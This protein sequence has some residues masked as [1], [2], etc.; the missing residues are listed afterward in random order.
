MRTAATAADILVWDED[1]NDGASSTNVMESVLEEAERAWHVDVQQSRI[2]ERDSVGH[3]DEVIPEVLPCGRRRI[4]WR[5]LVHEGCEARS[6]QAFAARF[7]DLA[8]AVVTIQ[9]ALPKG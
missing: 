7:P 5:A 8:R 6:A 1:G 3:Y 4:R 9:A 2:V